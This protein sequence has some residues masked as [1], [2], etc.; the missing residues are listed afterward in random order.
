M[1]LV[2]ANT[3]LAPKYMEVGVQYQADAYR[4]EALIDEAMIARSSNPELI[5]LEHAAYGLAGEV[6]EFIDQLKK[7]KYYGK[8]LDYVNLEEEIGDCMWYIAL[9]CNALGVDLQKVMD[10]N[11]A[12]LKVRF[13]D[14]FT[15]AEAITR[16]IAAERQVLEA[17]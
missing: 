4:T 2:G 3:T 6:G 1:F 13:A 17:T 7:H 15:Q 12:K 8:S 11:I 9:A 5:R 10:T 16:D 14:K